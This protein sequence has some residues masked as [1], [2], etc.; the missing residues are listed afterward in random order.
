M[1]VVALH[2][3]WT[4]APVASFYSMQGVTPPTFDE[5]TA[6]KAV[7]GF[8]DY[9]CGRMIKADFAEFVVFDASIFGAYDRDQRRRGSKTAKEILGW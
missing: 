5:E 9:F 1:K 4:A 2:K 3:L 8:I 6:K 7:D